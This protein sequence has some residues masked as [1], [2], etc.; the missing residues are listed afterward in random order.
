[1]IYVQSIA[2]TVNEE[3]IKLEVTVERQ[4]KSRPTQLALSMDGD[5]IATSYDDS[6]VEVIKLLPGG[7]FEVIFTN[8]LECDSISMLKLSRKA[9]VLFVQTSTTIVMINTESDEMVNI[10]TR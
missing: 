1:M 4:L 2:S 10:G 5:Y 8:E 7:K 9:A 3:W 6:T